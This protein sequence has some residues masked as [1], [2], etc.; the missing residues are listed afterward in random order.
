MRPPQPSLEREMRPTAESLGAETAQVRKLGLC[1]RIASVQH[2]HFPDR[3]HDLRSARL[4]KAFSTR[5]SRRPVFSRNA[6]FDELVVQQGARG[7]CD[8]GVGYAGVADQNDRV[9]MMGNLAHAFAIAG[10][11][12]GSIHPRILGRWS[13]NLHR[14]RAGIGPRAGGARK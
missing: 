7:F 6:H 11:E 2:H 14:R 3:L 8:H 12:G 10:G 4:G 13:R 9:E 1:V 5:L